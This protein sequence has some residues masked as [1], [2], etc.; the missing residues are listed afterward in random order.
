MNISSRHHYL[1]QFYLNGFTDDD[2]RFHV[3][4]I[5]NQ[6]LKSKK[7]FPKQVFFEPDRNTFI[8]GGEKTDFL[9]SQI[10][11]LI[12]NINSKAFQ[13]IVTSTRDSKTTLTDYYFLHYFITNLFWRIP[14]TDQ[15]IMVLFENANYQDLNFHLV[16][17]KIGKVDPI[18]SQKLLSLPEFRE[19]YRAFMAA[20]EFTKWNSETEMKNWRI[21]YSTNQNT[22]HLCGDNPIVTRNDGDLK[23]FSSELIF[24]LTKDKTLFYTNNEIKIKEISPEYKLKLDIVIMAQSQIMTTSIDSDYLVMINQLKNQFDIKQLKGELFEIFENNDN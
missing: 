11:K 24:P 14:R 2:R 20:T 18:A 8:I 1:P 7:L 17:N 22:P 23:L 13:K 5:K 19:T 15:Q 6:R 16:E 3:F 12:D 21:S 4:D 10:Y 9:E